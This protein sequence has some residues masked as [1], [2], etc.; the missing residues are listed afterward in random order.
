MPKNV[1]LVEDDPSLA[2]AIVEGLYDN[3]IKVELVSSVLPAIQ[4]IREKRPDAVIL[5]LML[6]DESGLDV[7]KAIRAQRDP[8]PVVIL[9]A[10]GSLENRVDGLNAGADD[11]LVK[12]FEMPELVARL[13]AVTR[14]NR[15][16]EG[17]NLTFGPLLLD[18]TTRRVF[19]E[20]KELKLSPTETSLIELFI[21]HEN[22]VLTRKMLCHQLWET[23][24]EGETNVIEVHINRLRSKLDKGS[25]RSLIH[26][27]RGRGYMLSEHEPKNRSNLIDLAM[28]DTEEPAANQP[29]QKTDSSEG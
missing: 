14:R 21:R 24:W 10:L 27:I 3:G 11:Y 8:T 23:T 15:R 25:D 19:R 12:P 20:G 1:L 7:L 4:L 29:S 6:S 26:T 5:D 16:L 9:T 18:L 28:L 22:Q 17:S 13:M 2:N